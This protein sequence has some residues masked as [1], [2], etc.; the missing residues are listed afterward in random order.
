MPLG[1]VSSAG[2]LGTNCA[3]KGGEAGS[4][5]LILYKADI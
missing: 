2:N 3:L 1:L 5:I 4:R